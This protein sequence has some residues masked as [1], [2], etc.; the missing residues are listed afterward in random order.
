MIALIIVFIVHEKKRKTGVHEKHERH[1][2]KQTYLLHVYSIT[3]Y[4]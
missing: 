1:E 2:K 3:S 4:F